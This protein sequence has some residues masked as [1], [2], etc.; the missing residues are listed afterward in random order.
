MTS[1]RL[2][3]LTFL[4]IVK[5][6]LIVVRVHLYLEVLLIMVGKV[7]LISRYKCKQNRKYLNFL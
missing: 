2:R 3:N 4:E 5:L 6:N 1:D 7:I